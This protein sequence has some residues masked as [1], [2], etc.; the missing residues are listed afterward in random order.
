VEHVARMVVMKNVYNILV[1]K[2]E[3]KR[4]LE[5]PRRR[6]RVIIKWVLT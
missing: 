2:P 1:T 4:L 6:W 3:G 5:R